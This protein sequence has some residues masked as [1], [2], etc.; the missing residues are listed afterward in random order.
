MKSG[1][2]P[3]SMSSGDVQSGVSVLRQIRTD[4]SDL[5]YRGAGGS[6]STNNFKSGDY[7][8]RNGDG[9]GPGGGGS[10]TGTRSTIRAGASSSDALIASSQNNIEIIVDSSLPSSRSGRKQS[11]DKNKSDDV[12]Q[13]Q[14][15]V[16][17]KHRPLFRRFLNYLKSAFQGTSTAVGK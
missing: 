8:G 11:V 14:K 10:S 9:G 4:E 2:V 1:Q 7:N 16:K 3:Q 12:E 13:G 5:I 15:K 6:T 17:H